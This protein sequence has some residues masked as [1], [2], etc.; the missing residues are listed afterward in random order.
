MPTPT[1]TKPCPKCQHG[2]MTYFVDP[3]PTQ[4]YEPLLEAGGGQMSDPI[5]VEPF[6]YY[7]CDKCGHREAALA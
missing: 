7:K 6:A 3:A 5:Q 4:Q 2:T 1:E